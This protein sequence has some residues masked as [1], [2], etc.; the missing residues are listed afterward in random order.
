[1]VSAIGNDGPLY[2]LVDQIIKLLSMLC[3]IFLLNDHFLLHKAISLLAI[4]RLVIDFFCCSFSSFM[5]GFFL[6]FGFPKRHVFFHLL[7]SNQYGI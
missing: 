2:G 5:A 3:L 1:M 6:C 7:P 4:V